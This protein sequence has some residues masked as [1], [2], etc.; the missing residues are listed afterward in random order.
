MTRRVN[1]AEEEGQQSTEGIRLHALQHQL[2][3]PNT[4]AELML[5]FE[6]DHIISESLQTNINHCTGVAQ[7]SLVITALVVVLSPW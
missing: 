5:Q 7:S 2:R 4:D 3:Y 6:V 1:D